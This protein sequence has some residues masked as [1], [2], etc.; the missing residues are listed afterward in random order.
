M[1]FIR[2]DVN[3]YIAY[4]NVSEETGHAAGCH[5][6]I[7]RLVKHDSYLNIGSC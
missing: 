1:P 5:D 2:P 7:A 3:R 6:G 4:L